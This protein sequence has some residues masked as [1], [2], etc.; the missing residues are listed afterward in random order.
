L[1]TF[2]A[3]FWLLKKND[4]GVYESLMNSSECRLARFRTPKLETRHHA[5][6]HSGGFGKNGLG[7]P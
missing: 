4:A 7:P 2:Q 5:P 3:G 1:D 6:R